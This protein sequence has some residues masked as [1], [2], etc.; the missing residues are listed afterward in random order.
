MMR[1]QVAA[2]AQRGVPDVYALVEAGLDI[3]WPTVNVRS[4]LTGAFA[5]P[6]ADAVGHQ[7]AG[8]AHAEHFDALACFVWLHRGALE[9]ALDAEIDASADDA[10]ALT[11][12]QR[13]KRLAE[14]DERILQA[15][16]ELCAVIEVAGGM[17]P[18][19][20]DPRAI[21]GI[22]GPAPRDR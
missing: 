9:R 6:A 5:M 2:H 11:Q 22:V 1:R 13:V 8:F 14:I 21:L 3:K 16:R 15:E 12:P 4:D 19:D 10:R 20:V 17:Y 7:L 18:P